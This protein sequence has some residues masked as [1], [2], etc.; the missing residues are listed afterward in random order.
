MTPHKLASHLSPNPMKALLG[1]LLVQTFSSSV[2][3]MIVAWF[4]VVKQS[5][6]TPFFRA[7][8]KGGGGGRVRFGTI[9]YNSTSRKIDQVV[10]TY[11]KFEAI[12]HRLRAFSRPDIYFHRP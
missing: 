1:P 12:G 7:E 10:S 4:V 6:P 9:L 3:V 11:R 8:K 2:N 5:E